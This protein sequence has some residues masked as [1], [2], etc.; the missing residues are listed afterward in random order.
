VVEVT[1][2]QTNRWH[3]SLQEKSICFSLIM[4]K[5]PHLIPLPQKRQ[6]IAVNGAFHHVNVIVFNSEI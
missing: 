1:D 6:L 3:E 5:V 4:L 2:Q